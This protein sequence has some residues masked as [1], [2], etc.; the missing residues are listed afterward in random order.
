[1][2][3][4]AAFSSPAVCGDCSPARR[5]TTGELCC[6]LLSP[7]ADAGRAGVLPVGRRA[8]AAAAARQGAVGRRRS[9]RR[10]GQ[11]RLRRR[12]VRG[13]ELRVRGAAASGRAGA[14]RLPGRR[15]GAGADRARLHPRL[16][17][18]GAELAS[19]G[20]A[21]DGGRLRADATA[22][23]SRSWLPTSARSEAGRSCCA[24]MDEVAY[25]QGEHTASP[26]K[27]VRTAIKHSMLTLSEAC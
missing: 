13:G 24:I 21:G 3:I 7:R 20:A 11:R 14:G 16:L 22:S 12:C 5:G 25:W 17:R 8:R 10:Q 18:A 27:E 9:A 15:Q 23:T 26:D 6:A 1:M 19:V 2:T 4:G